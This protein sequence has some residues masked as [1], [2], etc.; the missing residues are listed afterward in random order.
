[1]IGLKHMQRSKQADNYLYVEPAWMKRQQTTNPSSSSQEL[2]SRFQIEFPKI[3]PE[4]IQFICNTQGDESE[5][6]Q[7]LSSLHGDQESTS[8]HMPFHLELSGVPLD[9]SS[10]DSVCL[11]FIKY[12][13]LSHSNQVVMFACT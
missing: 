6:H 5:M 11:L 3:A 9:E 13:S 7:M 10:S 8:R 1:M 2:F 4:T 12:P